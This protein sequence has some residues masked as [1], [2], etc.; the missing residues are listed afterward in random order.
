MIGLGVAFKAKVTSL[1]FGARPAS[2]PVIPDRRGSRAS[3]SFHPEDRGTVAH[4]LPPIARVVV[5]TATENCPFLTIANY[6]LWGSR[7]GGRGS[8]DVPVGGAPTRGPTRTPAESSAVEMN[9]QG[10][11]SAVAGGGGNPFPSDLRDETLTALVATHEAPPGT[12]PVDVVEFE[13][14][15][16]GGLEIDREH[17]RGLAWFARAWLD[18]LNLDATKCAI[19]RVRGDLMEPALPDGCSIMFDRSRQD[20]REHGIYVVRTNGGLIVKRAVKSGRGWEL[21]SE[22]PAVAPEPWPA[23]AEV[24]G[25]VVWVAQTLV[26]PRRR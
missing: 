26:G 11:V 3:R 9:V 15:A 20:R 24:V 19:I 23:D 21:V 22:N 12:R 6:A 25:E 4:C 17:V 18:R 13:A 8:K 1:G 14:A 7:E 10:L 2:F 16:G 5:S